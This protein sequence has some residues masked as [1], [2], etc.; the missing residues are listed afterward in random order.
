MVLPIWGLLTEALYF[1]WLVGQWWLLWTLYLT[2]ESPIDIGRVAQ[3]ARAP[4][5]H[6]GSQ[7]FESLPGHCLV[8]R[9]NG[10]FG[11]IPVSGRNGAGACAFLIVT[12]P[13]AWRRYWRRTSRGLLPI[14]RKREYTGGAIGST[15]QQRL[16]EVR[17]LLGVL[18]GY[19]YGSQGVSHVALIGY[20]LN[21]P[22]ASASSID[23]SNPQ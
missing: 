4:P 22:L 23:F 7:G 12:R 14:T 9:T 11:F 10:G 21:Q 8:S 15:P 1:E 18:E 13:S 2:V 17:V 5:L 19:S 6:G 20:A 3:L 16:M